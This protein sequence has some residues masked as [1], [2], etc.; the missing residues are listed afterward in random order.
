[1]PLS[2]VLCDRNSRKLPIA[3]AASRKWWHAAEKLT[4][5]LRNKTTK[6]SL[7]PF[8]GKPGIG[9][10]RVLLKGGSTESDSGPL[11]PSAAADSGA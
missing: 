8:Q 11:L 5:D 6:V 4:P 1:M 2:K 7:L 10:E 9:Q 3:K